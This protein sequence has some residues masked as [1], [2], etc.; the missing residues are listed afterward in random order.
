MTR[1]LGDR[2]DLACEIREFLFSTVKPQCRL[3]VPILSAS[4]HR[5]VLRLDG[6]ILL[7]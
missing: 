2:L 5:V 6:R 4:S 3:H 1:V 7:L